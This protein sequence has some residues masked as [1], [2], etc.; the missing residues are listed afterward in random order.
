MSDAAC[1]AEIDLR[2]KSDRQSAFGRLAGYEDAND[3]DRLGGR[4]VT[5]AAA[6]TSRMRRFEMRS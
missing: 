2:V 6:L 3:A 4:A 1:E 5:E